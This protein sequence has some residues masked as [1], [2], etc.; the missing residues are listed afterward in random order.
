MRRSV[1]TVLVEPVE[2]GKDLRRGTAPAV[3]HHVRR[4]EVELLLVAGRVVAD[5]LRALLQRRQSHVSDDL[6]IGRL[7][8][9]LVVQLKIA[10]VGEAS[11]AGS[12][13]GCL[14]GTLKTDSQPSTT[15]AHV[16]D[17][18]HRAISS[19]FSR[20]SGFLSR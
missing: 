16:F 10:Q 18:A 4:K 6:F 17:R 13:V 11:I 20:D 12:G 8:W 5:R 15:A 2:H 1:G 19:R 3:F 9:N 7:Y 14:A